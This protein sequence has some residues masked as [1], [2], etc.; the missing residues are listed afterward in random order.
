MEESYFRRFVDVIEYQV[1]AGKGKIVKRKKGV[2]PDGL[3]VIVNESHLAQNQPARMRFLVEIDGSTHS[4]PRFGREKVLAGNAYIKSQAYKAR[5]GANSGRWIVLTGGEKRM[6]NLMHQTK[7]VADGNDAQYFIFTTTD[8]FFAA[9]NVLLDAI[10]WQV[11]KEEP[12][13]LL[14]PN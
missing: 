7:L 6:R 12:I 1:A 3:A 4:N 9:K 8:N 13:S 14:A 11:D 10:W 5:F 2:I